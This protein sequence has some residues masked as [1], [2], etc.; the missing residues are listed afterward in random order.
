MKIVEDLH[1]HTKFSKD[2]KE[3]PINYVNLAMDRDI[4]YLG[5]S[6]HID[7]DPFDKDFGYY[8]FN[9]TYEEYKRLKDF[10]DNKFELLFASELTYQSNLH[11][12]IE[13]EVLTKPFDYIIGSVHRI[14]GYTISGPHGV[15]YFKD[16]DEYTAYMRYF[17]EVL[18]LVE[19][20][21]YDIVGH[22]DVIKR[23][24]KNYYGEFHIDKYI[25]IITEILKIV[26]EKG[27][28]IEINA[29]AFR[30]GFSMPYPSKEILELY[31]NLGGR[32]VVLGSDS[33]SAK[34]FN[35]YLEETILFARSVFDFEIVS[36]KM[37]NKR[38]VSKL[39][40]LIK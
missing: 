24:G 36:Y 35:A 27:K 39:S 29:S 21:Y 18:R 30:Q 25:D 28:V 12:S 22:L 6:E 38:K 14:D 20:D 34:Q 40:N 11:S 10:V 2:S 3:E 37:R 19:T 17:E 8:K 16:I 7:L 32:E 5:F 9:E 23:Y 26:I 13:N 4:S 15:D 33:H 31:V 1:V